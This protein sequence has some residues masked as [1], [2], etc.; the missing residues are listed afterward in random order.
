MMAGKPVST[1]PVMLLARLA[2]RRRVAAMAERVGDQGRLLG[3]VPFGEA[4]RRRGRGLAPGIDRP[5][6]AQPG[7][8]EAAL[9]ARLDM[10]PIALVLR[11]LLRPDHLLDIGHAL[12]ACEQS[13]ARE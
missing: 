3:R 13:L 5:L 4:G 7:F 2:L 6:G 1:F 10:R 9:D 12:Q 11:L 8:A